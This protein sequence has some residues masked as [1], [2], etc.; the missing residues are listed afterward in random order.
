MTKSKIKV[1]P[2]AIVFSVISSVFRLFSTIHL[3]DA[4]FMGHFSLGRRYLKT[5][6]MCVCV[7]VC[8]CVCERERE[9]EREGEKRGKGK[10]FLK[11]K[12]PF[13]LY[14]VASSASP[15]QT[16]SARLGVRNLAY[17]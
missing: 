10:R 5:E 2:L 8:V 4:F 9:R 15:D 11:C 1:A 7:C 12:I 3:S 6:S 17:V 16:Y 13:L 14:P